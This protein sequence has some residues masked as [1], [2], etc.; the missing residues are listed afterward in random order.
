MLRLSLDAQTEETFTKYRKTHNDGVFDG[1]TQ[2]MKLARHSGIIL[3]YQMLMER[4]IIGDYRRVALYG[5][6]R[7]ILDK[8]NS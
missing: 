7:L 8:K 5:V 3:D 1:Y 6:D 4:K 2:E